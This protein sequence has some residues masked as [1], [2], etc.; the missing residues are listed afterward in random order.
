M[1]DIVARGIYPNIPFSE[2]KA[3]KAVSNSYLGRLDKC[4]AAGAIEIEDTPSMLIGRAVHKLVLEGLDAFTEEFVSLPKDLDRRTKEGKAAY[5]ELTEGNPGKNIISFADWQKA[6]A[7]YKAVKEHPWASKLL[8]E[9]VSEQTVIWEDKGTGLLCKSRPDSVPDEG[10]MALID[11]KTTADASEL[12]FTRSVIKYGYTRQA[13]M[14]LDGYNAATGSKAD[15]FIFVAV[16]TEPPYRT[17]VY[18]LDDDFISWGREEYKRLL[19]IEKKC[20]TEK[21]YPHYATPNI[22]QIFKPAYL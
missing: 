18:L 3:I 16:E 15:A 7:V 20:R 13:A 21:S 11:L 19:A 14:Y 22:V 5:A 17:E 4:P 12:A 10:K 9:N 6:C 2:Y 1:K 8:A